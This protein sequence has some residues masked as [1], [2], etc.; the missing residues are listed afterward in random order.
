MTFKEYFVKEF[1]AQMGFYP[2]IVAFGKNHLVYEERNC[3]FQDLAIKYPGLVCDTL[4]EAVH[5]GLHK[6][7][8]TSVVRLKCKGHGDPVCMYRAEWHG[9]QEKAHNGALTPTP[10]A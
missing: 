1:L 6:K 5:E 9:A 2:K 8:G 7:L 3:L 4:D 10:S